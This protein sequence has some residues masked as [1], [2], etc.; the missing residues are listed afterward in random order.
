[1]PQPT[2]VETQHSFLQLAWVL[3]LAADVL[4]DTAATSDSDSESDDSSE[5]SSDSDSESEDS[6]D[7][8]SDDEGSGNKEAA[9]LLELQAI[10]FVDLAVNLVGDGS[11]GPYFQFPKS[12][13]FFQCCLSA[14][15]RTFRFIFRIRIGRPMFEYLVEIL[16]T[17]PIFQSTGRKP[18]RHVK[19][20]LAAFL[21][22]YGSLGAD[23]Q[24]T[25]LKLSIGYGSVVLYCRRTVR[26]LR[27][28]KDKYV[29]FQSE[30]DQLFSMSE[31][32]AKTG[33]KNCIGSGDGSLI[34]F[35]AKPADEGTEYMG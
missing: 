33:F 12:Q 19:Y 17:H 6:D 21:I 13:D 14:P 27:E 28:L 1:M 29:G 18:Q 10:L 24:G 20:Q 32:E 7:S 4:R 26:A 35:A 34:Q 25:A 8:E 9:E 5:S 22:R 15:D 23:V 2:L 31:I 30:P 16:A 3:I 11:R